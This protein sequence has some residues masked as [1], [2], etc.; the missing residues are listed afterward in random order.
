[1]FSFLAVWIIAALTIAGVWWRPGGIREVWWAVTGALLLIVFRF[2]PLE[3]AGRAA[4][5]GKDVYLFLTGMMLLAEMAKRQ[6][7]FDWIAASAA[8]AAGGSS[9]RL[10]LLVYVAGVGVTALLSNDATAVVLTPAVLAVVR[11][12]KARPMPFLFICALV[13]N[14]ASFLLPISNPANLV[15]FGDHLPRLSQWLRWF[16]LPWMVSVVVTFVVLRFVWR[17]E[18]RGPLAA[19]EDAPKLSRGGMIT[20]CGLLLA[21]GALLTASAFE[22]PLGGPTCAAALGVLLIVT[23]MTSL[24]ELRRT[25]AEVSWSVI[26]LVAALFVIV[27]AV[28]GAGA[29]QLASNAFSRG[30]SLA[31]P[32]AALTAAWGTAGVANLINNLPAGLIAASGLQSAGVSTLMH[33][34]VL[35]GIDLGPSIAITGSLSTILWLTALR[36]E[37]SE[38]VKVRGV[39]F[40]RVGL[41]VTVPTLTLAT[42]AL[43]LTR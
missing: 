40:L 18:L 28:K 34:A 11:R 39:A 9:R 16:L 42:L 6:G 8:R 21:V 29:L 13:A 5:S 10:F 37:E 43:L 30:A 33:R 36:K 26:P 7:L 32:L 1:M 35:I 14:A 41:L 2:L 15:V 17:A 25:L 24:E 23:S 12:A 31:A 19:E 3:D 27:E 20:A 38:E 4:W 22:V